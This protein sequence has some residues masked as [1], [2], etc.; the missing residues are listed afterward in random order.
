M[1]LSHTFRGV[2]VIPLAGSLNWGGPNS[3]STR[4]LFYFSLL[5]WLGTGRGMVGTG[6]DSMGREIERIAS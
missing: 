4:F 6:I 3:T 2:P 1:G 5:G